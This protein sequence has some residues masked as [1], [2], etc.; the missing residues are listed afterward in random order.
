MLWIIIGVFAV[1]VML[2]I[3]NGTQKDIVDQIESLG[4]NLLTISAWWQNMNMRWGEPTDSATLDEDMINYLK[5]NVSNLSTITPMISTMA[6]ASYGDYTTH[7]TIN[8][9]QPDYLTVKN[10]EVA[11]GSFITT[12]DVNTLNKVAVLWQDIAQ[13]LFGSWATAIDPIGQDIKLWNIV[14]TI[15][16]VLEDSMMNNSIIF[17]PLTTVSVRLSGIRDYSSIAISAIDTDVINQTKTDLETSLKSYL[18]L[19]DTDTATFTV[20]SQ[21]DIIDAVG[22]IMWI[23][24]AFLAGIAAISLLVWGIW[25]M[26]I[27]LVS[28]TERTKEIGIR[29]AIGAQRKDILL[30]FLTESLIL[31]LM[32][33]IIWI[34]LSFITVIILNN[35]LTAIISFGAV[36]LAFTSAVS[37]GIIFGILPAN[38]ASKLKP[39]EALRYE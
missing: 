8:G 18:G 7:A 4:T 12:Q 3:G 31:S 33:G 23:M 35:F 17:V 15:I 24:T 11:N 34:L 20:Q 29:K 19:S 6:T 32:W 2:A 9:I 21:S 39:I 37:I 1:V 14:V 22:D 27:M 30:Q 36:V 25:V 38:S 13:D 28:V 16:G 10:L 5:A 26:N